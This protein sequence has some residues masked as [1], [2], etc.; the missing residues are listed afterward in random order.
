[1]ESW[2]NEAVTFESRI[3][4]ANILYE[5]S[6]RLWQ[7]ALRDPANRGVRWVHLRNQPGQEDDVW[8]ALNGTPQLL[9]NYDLVYRDAGRLI[10]RYRG[11]GPP[12]PPPIDSAAAP[13]GTG[14]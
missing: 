3:P 2:G 13:K 4:T 6:F 10:Y 1:M 8:R 5:G 9:N 7:P 14:S 12:V 11:S